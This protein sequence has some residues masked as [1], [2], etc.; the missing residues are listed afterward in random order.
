VDWYPWGE[1]AFERARR[2]NKPVFL[3]IGYSACHWCHVMERE[4]F[5]DEEIARVLNER[6]IS[7]KVDREEHPEVDAIYMNAVQLMSGTGGWPLTVFLTP[8]LKPFFGG[9]YFPPTDRQDFPGFRRVLEEIA[10]VYRDGHDNVVQTAEQLTAALRQYCDI[11]PRG[12]ADAEL[13]RHLLAAA[14]RSIAASFDGDHGG[15]GQAPKFPQ[16]TTL[17]F[18]LRYYA[19]TG[20]PHALSML[21]TTLEHMARGG[22]YDQLGGGFHRYSTDA[23]WLVPHFEKMLNDNALLAGVYLDAWRATR[24]RFYERIV[25]ETLD[26]VLREMTGAHGGFYTAQDADSE[27]GEGE[28]FVWTAEGIQAAVGAK[29]AAV[30]MRHF[31]VEP[32]GNFE[33]AKSVLLV[34]ATAD[35]VAKQL[36]LPLAE[37]E[38]AI[39]E[40]RQALLERRRE[41]TAPA[42]DDKIIAAWNGLMISAMAR[43]GAV[44]GEARYLE[45][46]RRSADFVLTHMRR[47]DGGLRRTWRQGECRASGCL[48]DYA[49]LVAGL[50]DLFEATFEPR[51]LEQAIALAETMVARFYDERAG[52]FF[53]SE[54]G[55]PPT[56]VR[57]KDSYDNPDPSGNSM[58]VFDLLRLVEL[59]ER[60]PW[61]EKA[62]ATLKL[63]LPTM[64]KAPTATG[65]ML[66]ALDFHTAPPRLVVIAGACG[67]PAT[68]ALIEAARHPLAPNNILV[69]ADLADTE[70]LGRM[71]RFVPAIEGK[72]TIGA[73]PT[74]YVC[75]NR[76]CGPPTNDPDVLGREMLPG[77]QKKPQTPRET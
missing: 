14:F 21:E 33:D 11:E 32:I 58:A 63:F 66:S 12:R 54:D 60:E 65:K 10:A 28:S 13:S 49:F 48:T 1:E 47:G 23:R 50:L 25:R 37:V 30:V 31:G 17:A 61:R 24:N 7:I 53:F 39:A 56:L 8:D 72:A 6:F 77:W 19:A 76:T 9:T 22:I 59:T 15:F 51:W 29:N 57:T 46:A 71:Q 27:G 44:F 62:L 74:A 75:Q 70:S 45:A 3:S 67:D 35:E 41:R 38:K 64:A 55:Q 73:P 42:T 16:P 18:L 36:R 4:S 34:A 20:E 5:E 2:E 26:Y 69:L 52:G 68:R 40:G 43:A